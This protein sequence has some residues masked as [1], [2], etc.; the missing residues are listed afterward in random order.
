ME[1]ETLS[2]SSFGHGPLFRLSARRSA[3]LAADAVS[4]MEKGFFLLK[5]ILALLSLMQVR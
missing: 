4:S 1:R 2:E 3:H 5:S